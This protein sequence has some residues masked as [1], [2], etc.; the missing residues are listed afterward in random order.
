MR[1]K[2]IFAALSLVLFIGGCG[3]SLGSLVPP[4]ISTV[5]VETFD[6]KTFEKN[7][8]IEITKKIKERYNW[9]GSLKA[10]NSKEEADAVLEGEVVNYVRQ[11][12]RYSQ[13]DDKEIDEYKLVLVINLKFIDTANDKVIWSEENFT[14]EAYYVVSGVTATEQSRVRANSEAGAFEFA[15]DDLAQNVVDRTIEGW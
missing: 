7:I 5:Y 12:A 14:G 3:Y 4:H 10:V 1:K 13:V 9:D 6:N 15:A 8:E 11:A 2:Y